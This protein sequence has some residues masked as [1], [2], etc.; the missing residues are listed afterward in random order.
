M[1][2]GLYVGSWPP[3]DIPNGI[4]I[5]ASQLVPALRRLGHQVFVFTP[6][7][8]SDNDPCTVDLRNFAHPAT[9]WDRAMCRLLPDI[10]L[11]NVATSAIATAVAEFVQKHKIEVFEIEETFGFSFA[12]SRLKLLP[13]VVR[14]H[15]PWFLNGRFYDLDEPTTQ[16][17]RRQKWEGRGIQHA[18]L[19]TAPSAEV[20]Q[21]V[22][23]HYGFTLPAS[24]IIRNSLATPDDG[25]MWDIKTCNKNSLLFVGRF[26]RLKGGDLVL[27][28]FAKLAASYPQL[29]L[30][31]VGPDRGVVEA[32]GTVSGFEQFVG[33]NFPAWLRSRIKFC[34]ELKHSE[35]MALRRNH[36][37]TIIAS[38]R[39]IMPYSVLEAMSLGCPLIATSVGGIPELIEDQRNGLLVPSQDVKAMINACKKLLDDHTL[40]ARLGRQAR[41]DCHQLYRPDNIAT[42]TISAYNQ[43]IDSF[44]RHTHANR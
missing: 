36:F 32:D 30:T 39:E 33:N 15:G 3:G 31:F 21:L 38:Q 2:I 12:I 35:V 10:G 19:V 24:R 4:V 7:R 5:Y 23:D 43:A 17:R 29:K 13:V 6:H 44:K 11:F 26:D 41:Q 40:A 14:L 34:G 20:L 42:Q 1:K 16:N 27:R 8:T 22:K 18:Q 9:L 28:V 25:K 37:A